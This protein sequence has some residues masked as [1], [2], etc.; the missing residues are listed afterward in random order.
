MKVKV[1]VKVERGQNKKFG[2]IV[3]T[4]MAHPEN[5]RQAFANFFGCIFRKSFGYIFRK[6]DLIVITTVAHPGNTRQA[7]ANFFGYIFTS[8]GKKI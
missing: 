6:F 3:I 1:K 7:F 4:T 2:L 5:T 8:S